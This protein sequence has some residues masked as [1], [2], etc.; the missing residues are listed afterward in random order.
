MMILH[1]GAIAPVPTPLDGNLQF[2]PVAQ[3]AHLSWLASEG[4][5]GVLVLGTNGEFPS[6]SLAERIAVAE[7]A[8]AAA[9]GMHLILGVGSCA[10]PEVQTMLDVA[11]RCGYEAVLC[12]P[13]FY[14]RGAPAG[15]LAAFFREVLDTSSVPVLLY[16][17]PQVTG[18]PISEEIL[19]LLEGHERL[20]GVKDSSGNPDE[21]ARLCGRFHDRAYIV[22]SDR[23]VTACLAAGGRGSITAASNVVPRLV[24]A[25]HRGEA[26]QCELDALRELLEDSGLGPSVKAILRRAG[27]GE[28]ATRP[29]LLGLDPSNEEALWKA[30]C[31]LVPDEHRPRTI[32][33]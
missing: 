14:F 3:K 17:I 12:P 11:A 26:A 13:P 33:R 6:F 5:D 2:D 1:A 9:A 18:M 15:G 19:D 10:L 21:L 16:H 22:G 29:P 31:R 7:T 20:V 4:L 8:A 25:V 28:F 24:R 23:L 27:L 30:Y 32:E